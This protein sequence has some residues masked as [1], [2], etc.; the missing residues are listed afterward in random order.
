MIL[1][2]CN[3]FLADNFVSVLLRASLVVGHV[4]SSAQLAAKTSLAFC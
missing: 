3:D 1:T 4:A 2:S